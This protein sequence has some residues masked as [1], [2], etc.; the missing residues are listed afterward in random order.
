MSWSQT[1]PKPNNEAFTEDEHN[2]RIPLPKYLIQKQ[3]EQT[4]LSLSQQNPR[5]RA[6]VVWAGFIYGNGEQNDIFYEFFRRA[7][8]SLHPNLAALPVIEKGNNNLPTV[9]VSDLTSA[10]DLILTE[11][12]SFSSALFAV[13]QSPS[14]TQKEIMTAISEGIGSGATQ[15]VS[16]SEVVEEPW[17]EFLQVDVKLDASPDLVNGFKWKCP[18]GIN[19]DTMAMLND[20]FNFFRGLFP[21]KVFIT[22]PPCSGKTYFAQKLV[23]QYGV[24]H[25][26]IKDVVTMGMQLTNDYGDKLKAKIEELK[27]QAEAEYEKTR[28]KK[29]PD[30]DRAACNPRLPEEVLYDLVKIQLNSAGCMN[31]GFILDGFPRSK[32]DA[33]NVFM[34]KIPVEKPEGE[35]QEED[36]E[37][38]FEERLNERIVPQYAIALEADDPSLV[39]RAKELPPEKVENGHHNDAGMTRRLKEYRARNVDESGETVKDFFNE[40]IGYQNVLVVDSLLPEEEQIV[41]MQEIIE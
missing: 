6:H 35:E 21:L 27:D 9:H 3:L 10:I 17:C 38:Q 5:L 37:P 25:I 39:A 13:D 29:D 40:A 7:W 30:F 11:G 1:P 4:A 20:E 18:Q 36:A 2:R 41:K 32:E 22:G 28:K 24:P 15:E 16:I 34:D 26:T 23:E 31:K 12:Q 14:S 19:K 33:K 8:V